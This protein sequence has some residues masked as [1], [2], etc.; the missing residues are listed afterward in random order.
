MSARRKKWR[1]LENTAKIFPATS[2]KKDERVF[3]ISC[4]LKEE[5]DESV[6]ALGMIKLAVEEDG[7]DYDQMLEAGNEKGDKL[8]MGAVNALVTQT[9]SIERAVSVLGLSKID[10]EGSYSLDNPNAVF[11]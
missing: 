10:F 1:M 9:A 6:M 7:F 2:G 8:I 3:R 4:Q 5:V 11:Q